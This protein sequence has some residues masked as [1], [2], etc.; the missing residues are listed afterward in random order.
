[1]HI[2]SGT[3]ECVYPQVAAFVT[4]LKAANIAHNFYSGKEMMHV[5]P[6]I[7]F[8]PECGKALKLIFDIIEQG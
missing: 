7:P 2:F 6:Y 3:F 5:W 1:M 4:R 8:A